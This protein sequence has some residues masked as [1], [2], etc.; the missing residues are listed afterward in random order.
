MTQSQIK[1]P[2]SATHNL[3]NV[4]GLC[5][6]LAAAVVCR[7][8]GV[9][10]VLA[11]LGCVSAYIAVI[12]LLEVV[13]LKT[14]KRASAGLDFSAF[15]WDA[16]RVY[17]KLIALYGCYGL[18]GLG[19]WAFAHYRQELFQDYWLVLEL[20]GPMLVIL[21]GPYVALV[22]GF[23]REP[24]DTYYHLGRWLAGHGLFTSGR[25]AGQLVMGWVV[26]GY[27]LPLMF[28]YMVDDVNYLIDLTLAGKEM[29]F[30]VLLKIAITLVFILDL[31][32]AVSGYASTFRLF[33][34]HIRSVEPTFLGWAACLA[35]YTPFNSVYLG[36]YTH[37]R[38]EDDRWS[39][40]LQAHPTLL[41][42]W[43]GMV[44][45]GVAAYSVAGLNY[46]VRFSNLT[47]R[48][49]LTSGMYRF[50]KHPEYISKN[51]FWWL[52][53]VPFVAV[54]DGEGML[55][56]ARYLVMMLMIN[57]TYFIRARTEERHLSRDK[58]YVRYALWMN[59]HGALAWLGRRIPCLQ[60]QAPKG[61]EAL[62]EVYGGIR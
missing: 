60:Y 18:V 55:D 35:C 62:P 9:R 41:V 53:Y 50:T 51:F 16:R 57:A 27:F 47:H 52:T 17:Y 38:G 25:A 45:A 10:G 32:A 24:E 7:Q 13:F 58:E 28:V 31:L 4:M 46:G 48:G 14:P 56:T 34:T 30:L 11:T 59:E 2:A 54:G 33:D 12:L 61:W 15:R 26:K 6:F 43:G 23:M 44:L 40:W 36:V 8:V 1:R 3:I 19:Y 29:D 39:I 42:V 20:V 5:A 49:I 22:D 21:A 37:Y